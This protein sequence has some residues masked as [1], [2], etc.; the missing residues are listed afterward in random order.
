[1]WWAAHREG[2]EP[3]THAERLGPGSLRRLA[4]RGQSQPL[5]EKHAVSLGGGGEAAAKRMPC[6]SCG[7]HSGPR[8]TRGLNHRAGRDSQD[9]CVSQKAVGG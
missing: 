3:A 5:G 7:A 9:D 6:S 2:R 4:P 8:A 1:M